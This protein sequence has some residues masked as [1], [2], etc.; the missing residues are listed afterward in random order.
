MWWGGRVGNRSGTLLARKEVR[1][2]GFVFAVVVVVVLW[3]L[4]MLPI[5][6]L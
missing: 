2:H 1:K 5:K 4:Q 6:E 3:F